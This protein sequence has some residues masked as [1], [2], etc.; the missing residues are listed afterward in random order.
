VLQPATDQHAIVSMAALQTAFASRTPTATA[1]AVLILTALLLLAAMLTPTANKERSVLWA[2]VVEPTFAWDHV[3]VTRE[4]GF[5][6][7]VTS[8]GSTLVDVRLHKRAL[9]R[10]MGSTGFIHFDSSIFFTNTVISSLL[11][12]MVSTVTLKVM[13][14]VLSFLVN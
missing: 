6:K 5:W 13:Q 1:S 7:V 12:N 11:W 10:A 9:S 3:L 14:C 2:L 4:D 8:P